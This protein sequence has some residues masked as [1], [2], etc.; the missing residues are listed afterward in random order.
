VDQL[1]DKRAFRQSNTTTFRERPPTSP[2]IANR[3][4]P[5]MVVDFSSQ[6]KVVPGIGANNYNHPFTMNRSG[7]PFSLQTMVG[8]SG[9][10]QANALGPAG[11][12]RGASPVRGK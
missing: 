9:D 7:K 3:G 5:K 6:Q 8:G 1:R 11:P 4:A 10:P 2:E 12:R